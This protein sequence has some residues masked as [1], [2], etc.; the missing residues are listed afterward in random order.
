MFIQSDMLALQA[1]HSAAF[2]IECVR[3]MA[4][5]Y[6]RLAQKSFAFSIRFDS[7]TIRVKK[8]YAVDGV[9]ALVCGYTANWQSSSD[10]INQYTHTHITSPYRRVVES[11]SINSV[12]RTSALLR[13]SDLAASYTQSNIVNVIY[14]IAEI[15]SIQ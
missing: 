15:P 2:R 8:I 5:T 12:L 14:D 11:F 9:R 7:A 13:N 1:K 6:N 4:T 10:D 3:T